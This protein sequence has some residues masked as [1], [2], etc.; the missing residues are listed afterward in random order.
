GPEP[1]S[2]SAESIKVYQSPE[3]S[4]SFPASNAIDSDATTFTH[5]ENSP[6]SYWMADLRR[7]APVDRI[8]LINRAT[9]CPER[10]GGLI[11][12][13][14]DAASNSVFSAVVPNPGL[15]GK[16]TTNLPTGTAGRYFRF[17]SENGQTNEAGNYYVTLAEAR[18]FSG[19]TNL[20]L[21]GTASV[22]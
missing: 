12:R 14:F 6:N 5:T 7:S 4:P 19:T 21:A 8:E 10:M 20:F 9:C 1:I 11:F 18:V 22:P 15:G 16:W 3:Y 17:G 2:P 13:I